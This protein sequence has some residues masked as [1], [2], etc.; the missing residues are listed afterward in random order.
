M[1]AGITSGEILPVIK[2]TWDTTVVCLQ[3]ES[4]AH[5]AEVD[6]NKD[7]SSLS[8]AQPQSSMANLSALLKHHQQITTEK[9]VYHQGLHAELQSQLEQALQELRQSESSH[10]AE[11]ASVR[12]QHDQQLAELQSAHD[13]ALQASY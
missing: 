1:T 3:S 7:V 4:E 8:S 9:E 5:F 10:A 13:S 2:G 6:A 11:L 12:E